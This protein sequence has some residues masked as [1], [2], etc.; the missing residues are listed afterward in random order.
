MHDHASRG[1]L[2]DPLRTRANLEPGRPWEQVEKTMTRTLAPALLASALMLGCSASA[3]KAED[4]PKDNKG[5][6]TPKSV[7]IDLGAEIPEMKGWQLRLRELKIEQGGH[8]GL[9]SHKDRPSVVIFEQGTDTVTNADG[10]SKT[11]HPGD[12]TA[13]GVKTVHWHNN[14]GQDAIVLFTAD[15]MKAPA[16]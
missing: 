12:T 2:I 15:L 10:S 8:I 13:E 6:T 7:T 11:F 1:A 3:G 16:K 5:Y 9:H 14:A 4:A